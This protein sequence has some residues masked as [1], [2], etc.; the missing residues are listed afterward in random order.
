MARQSTTENEQNILGGVEGIKAAG[1]PYPVRI[2][3][4]EAEDMVVKDEFL[5]I[6]W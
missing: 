6:V 3:R 2:R 4:G 5:N 1:G